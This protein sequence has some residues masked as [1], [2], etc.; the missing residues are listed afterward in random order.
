MHVCLCLKQIKLLVTTPHSLLSFTHVFSLHSLPPHLLRES[1]KGSNW[2]GLC[3][4]LLWADKT[5][6]GPRRLFARRN[7]ILSLSHER[8]C[9]C[10]ERKRLCSRISR[11]G[12]GTLQLFPLFS[13]LSFPSLV[14]LSA[15]RQR[16]SQLSCG[17]RRGYSVKTAEL[18][19]EDEE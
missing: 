1:I 6:Q 13:V 5:R 17:W 10:E 8:V 12:R 11:M 2:P 7:G 16:G 4:P 14:S 19:R 3:G 18:R 9:L 15:W